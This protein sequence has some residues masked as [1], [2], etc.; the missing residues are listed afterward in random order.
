MDTWLLPFLGQLGITWAVCI[1]SG[2][3]LLKWIGG[4]WIDERVRERS[5]AR[6]NEQKDR[7]SKATQTE[8]TSLRGQLATELASHTDSLN[9]VTQKKYRRISNPTDGRQR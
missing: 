2:Y 3:A 1:G 4:K 8:I 9:R 6:L 5:E 7:L